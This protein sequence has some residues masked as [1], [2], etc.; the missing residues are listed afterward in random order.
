MRICPACGQ[1]IRDTRPRTTG[2]RSQSNRF[3]GGC[4]AIAQQLPPDAD[5]RGYRAEQ[6]AEAIKR[7]AVAEGYPTYLDEMDG[8]EQ[9]QSE[10]DAS[11]EQAGILIKVL[12]RFADL[13]GMWLWEYDEKRRAYKSYAGQTRGKT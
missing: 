7:M 12:Q 5:G 4:R 1:R 3:R 8:T 9:A 13:H 11:M 2:P 10:A 6:V